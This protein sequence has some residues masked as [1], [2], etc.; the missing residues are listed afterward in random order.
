MLVSVVI[1]AL[2]KVA[3]RAGRIALFPAVFTHPHESCVPITDDKWIISTF[4]LNP[5]SGS[6]NK[7]EEHPHHHD[8]PELIMGP[9]PM[10][11]EDFIA[12]I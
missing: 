7:I 11:F 8:E 2:V 4:I 12:A 10:D 6:L 9:P 1:V 5:E 3:P